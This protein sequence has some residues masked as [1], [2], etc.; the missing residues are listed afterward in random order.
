MTGAHPVTVA[1]LVSVSELKAQVHYCDHT[2]AILRPLS[3]ITFH[4][5]RAQEPKAPVTYCDHALSGVRPSVRR[6]LSVV[7]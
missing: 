6:L 3:V 1:P 7:R 2:S 5:F 4:I